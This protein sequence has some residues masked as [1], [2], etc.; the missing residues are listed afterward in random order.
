MYLNGCFDISF[1]LAFTQTLIR[2]N[3]IDK[4]E[5][6]F[7]FKIQFSSPR[8]TIRWQCLFIYLFFFACDS[9]SS[10]LDTMYNISLDLKQTSVGFFFLFSRIHTQL[11]RLR[12]FVRSVAKRFW[13]LQ[14]SFCEF[15]W[16]LNDNHC[17]YTPM[18][19]IFYFINQSK[20]YWR[21][22]LIKNARFILNKLKRQILSIKFPLVITLF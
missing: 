6:Y 11:T 13:Y 8:S 1:I 15:Y 10:T 22:N 21:F 12:S 7:F 4:I 19:L 16:S 20:F 18:I 17:R 5:L 14:I 2:V 3:F 9:K